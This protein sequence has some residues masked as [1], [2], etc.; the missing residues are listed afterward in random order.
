MV[1]EKKIAHYPLP[2]VKALV[3]KGHLRSTKS[4]V[5]GAAA[6]G[7]NFDDMKEVIKSLETGDFYKSMTSHADHAIWQD[8][9]RFPSEAG[10]IYIKLSVIDDVLIVSFKEL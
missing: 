3:E 2:G 4:A 10:D 8:V 5:D 6:L 9:Y 7:L 1:M